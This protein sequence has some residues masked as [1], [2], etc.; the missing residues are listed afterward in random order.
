LDTRRRKQQEN[1]TDDEFTYEM[2][3]ACSTQVNDQK[4]CACKMLAGYGEKRRLL[5]RARRR[6]EDNIKMD[7]EGCKDIV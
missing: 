3:V 2:G 5:R 4:L 7:L 6:W 1:I